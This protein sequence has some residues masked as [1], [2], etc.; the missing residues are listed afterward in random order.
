[1]LYENM[2]QEENW[3]DIAENCFVIAGDDLPELCHTMLV[4]NIVSTSPLEDL[5]L[6]I[7]IYPEDTANPVVPVE[8]GETL[9]DGGGIAKK[10]Q[11][12]ENRPSSSLDREQ[13]PFRLL[14]YRGS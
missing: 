9:K 5:T 11:S 7:E 4:Q 10:R 13:V 6:A 3:M 12:H 2:Q 8:G 1:M 14:V